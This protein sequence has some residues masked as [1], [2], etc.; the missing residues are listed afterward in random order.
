MNKSKKDLIAKIE[1][2]LN[3]VDFGSIEIIVQGSKVTQI[4]VRKIEKTSLDISDI[5][6][7]IEQKNKT[8]TIQAHF[9]R[10]D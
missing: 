4:S 9:R 10:T 5:D 7:N 8:F 2:A 3:T 6:Q 1:S